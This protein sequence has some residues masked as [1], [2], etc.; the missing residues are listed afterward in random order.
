M[1]LLNK[2]VFIA[3]CGL[4]ASTSGIA[5]DQSKASNLKTLDQLL[6]TVRRDKALDNKVNK[7]REAEFVK[8]KNK[9]ASM[10]AQAKKELAAQQSRGEKL[11][12]QFD[13][14]EKILSELETKRKITMGTLGELFG[15][16]RQVAGDAKGS[17]ET[18][19]VTAENPGRTAL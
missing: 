11:K 12:A 18:S 3:L 5:Q 14:N 1:N 4:L 9:R 19:L 15:V 10:L 6:E 13:A 7:Q 2:L 17:F 16:V 8:N